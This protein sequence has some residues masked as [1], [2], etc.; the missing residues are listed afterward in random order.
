[1]SALF[2]HG[3]REK[4]TDPMGR[5]KQANM[6]FMRR[7]LH[8]KTANML[9][10]GA[11]AVVPIVAMVGSGLDMS[12]AFLVQSRMQQACDSA[13]LA[14][15]KKLSATET[16]GGVISDDVQDIANDFFAANFSEG[17]YGSENLDFTLTAGTAT[18]MDGTATA[19]LP[20]ALM[21]V[22][23]FDQFDIE[24]NCS[25]ELNLPNI[26]VMLVL[27]LS[28]SMFTN[29]RIGSLKQAV[30]AFYDEVHAVKPPNARIRI[31]VVPYSGN[32]NVGRVLFDANPAW[33]ADRWNYQTREA[34]FSTVTTPGQPEREERYFNGDEL[35]PQS[36]ASW[37]VSGASTRWPT[38]TPAANTQCS[39]LET[40]GSSTYTVGA[41]RWVITSDTYLPNNFTTGAAA[42]RGAC[43]VRVQKFRRLAATPPTE[44][45]VFSHYLHRQRELDTSQYKRFVS[46]STNTGVQGAAV[47]STWN[48]CIEERQ[49]V[50]Q[51]NWPEV[52]A[53]ALDLDFNT[54]P[55]AANPATQW[56]PQWRQASFPRTSRTTQL[57]AEWTTTTN[58]NSYV[59]D[60]AC[61]SPARK[62][63]EYP[64]FGTN[65]NTDFETYINSLT[66]AGGTMH[67]IGMIWGARFLTPNGLFSAENAS[68]PNGDPI[69]R[70]I[71][72]MSDGEMG[73]DPA[74]YIAYGH[75]N[76]DGRFLGFRG[77]GQRWSEEDLAAVHNRRLRALCES[78]KNQNVT[79]FTIMFDLRQN[80]F[81]RGCASGE[82]RA[83]EAAGAA[84]LVAT[85]REIAG[86]VA[87][88]RLVS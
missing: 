22:V 21:Q 16:V 14:A 52:P 75:P 61:P 58:V 86:N 33:I 39:A 34:V 47:N 70:Y 11:A 88:L 82:E 8:D 7:L 12:R 65:R 53:A 42:S 69:R 3:R 49:T 78:I 20:T 41:E 28:S 27:D 62:M 63:R 59:N 51:A 10:I 84:E 17:S 32:V 4:G 6:S 36:Q 60:A 81:T 29:N 87:E 38:N 50:A 2:S 30:L 24:V 48:G 77:A 67:D 56:K 83:Y 74:N 15:R 71:V 55:T 85:F 68:A 73:A 80:E 79:V 45:L 23:G 35:I 44:S 76:M 18:R 37:G 25:A 1:M 66:P 43:R 31:G 72:F 40:S 54:V 64:L 9:A 19:D 46:A 5:E 57:P 13:T 26:D